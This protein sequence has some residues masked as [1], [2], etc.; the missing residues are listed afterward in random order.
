MNPNEFA[1]TYNLILNDVAAIAHNQQVLAGIQAQLNYNIFNPFEQDIIYEDH[2]GQ[3][4]SEPRQFTYR[5]V[6][7]TSRILHQTGVSLRDIVGADLLYEIVDEK[8]GLIQYKRAKNGSVRNDVVQLEVLLN[9]CPDMCSN[10]KKRPIPLNWIPLRLNAFCGSWYCVFDGKER[11]YVHACEAEA[12]FNGKGSAQIHYFKTGLTKESFL[13][14][15]SSCRIGALLRRYPGPIIRPD[16]YT[17]RLLEQRH[18]ILEVRQQ[19]RWVE[20]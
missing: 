8:F 9:N 17:S 19:G 7:I 12:I 20:E 11:M 18:I 4:P 13:E 2:F 5:G 14:L 3:M 1:E 10:K 15:F 6:T 16:I